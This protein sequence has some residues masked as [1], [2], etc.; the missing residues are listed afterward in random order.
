MSKWQTRAQRRHSRL[1]HQL[2]GGAYPPSA[3]EI[4]IQRRWTTAEEM[5]GSQWVWMTPGER[6]RVVA[7]R[8]RWINANGCRADLDDS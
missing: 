8:E 2:F 3:T 5:F 1:A 7:E 4:K 6:G